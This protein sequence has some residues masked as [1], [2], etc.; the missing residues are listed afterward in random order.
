M[1][2]ISLL[3]SKGGVGKTSLSV[4]LA[5]KA[6]QQGKKVALIDID[7]QGSLTEWHQSRDGDSPILAQCAAKHLPEMLQ[8]C[9]ENSIDLVIIDTAPHSSNEGLK[10][11]KLSDLALIPTRPTILDLRA[12]E[13]S[14]IIADK[15]NCQRAVIL[16][17]CPSP[18]GFG[19][20]AVVTEA[21]KVLI[22]DYDVVVWDKCIV[23]RAAY[24]YSLINGQ[25]VTEYE[26]G[27]K[28]AAEIDSLWK[29]IEG[30]LK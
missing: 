8:E 7:P 24:Q 14:L 15:A 9:T 29:W 10:A 2:V 6:G 21:R 18:R 23:H 17:A 1:H 25:G 26:A 5:V 3:C 13:S 30:L 19:E 20:N 12:I 4:H 11:A 27:G 16:S 22:N 28:A